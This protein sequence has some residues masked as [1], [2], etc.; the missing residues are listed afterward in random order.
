MELNFGV[1]VGFGQSNSMLWRFA[2]CMRPGAVI[3]YCL[4]FAGGSAYSYREFQKFAPDFIRIYPVELPGRGRRFS[5]PL[6]TDVH[7]MVED[8]LN[9]IGDNLAKPYALFG[10]SLGA[11]LAHLL[12]RRLIAENLPLP[13]HLFITGRAGP[14]VK[15]KNKDRHLLPKDAFIKVL[16]EFEGTP[17]EVLKSEELMDLFVPI[18]K[19]DFQAYENYT[20][21]KKDPFDIPITVIIGLQDE[22]TREEASKWQ[23]ETTQKITVMAFPGGHFFIYDYLPETMRII[24]RKL[25]KEMGNSDRA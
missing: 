7:A 1:R 16:D 3:L 19:A 17:P 14:S 5:E 25:Q 12:V 6:I 23:E 2:E 13:I 18:I 15:R 9:Q 24:S 10:H 11:T 22:T 4:P 8:I 21:E 20:Y